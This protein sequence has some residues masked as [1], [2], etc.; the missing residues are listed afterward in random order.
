MQAGC[1]WLS[2]RIV[3]QPLQTVPLT[4]MEVTGGVIRNYGVWDSPFNP[5]VQASRGGFTF[6]AFS[7]VTECM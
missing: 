4:S 1:H 3:S 2:K 5:L 6:L 7:F